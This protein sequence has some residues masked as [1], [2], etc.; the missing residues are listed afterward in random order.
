MV[1]K[2]LKRLNPYTIIFVLSI[3]I[4]FMSVLLYL[5]MNDTKFKQKK[6]MQPVEEKEQKQSVNITNIMKGGDDTYTRAPVPLRDSKLINIPT[7]GLPEQYQ[8]MGTLK[9]EEGTMLPLY[10]RRVASRSDRFNYYTRTD[11]YNPLPLPLEYNKKDC[12][13]DIGC[14]E[15]F[16]GDTVKITPTGQVASASLYKF[17]G[18]TYY[19]GILF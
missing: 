11:T 3:I 5:Y 4:V 14:N 2:G 12:Q 8:A 13:D 7:Q 9:T 1:A 19:P 18:P 17:G 16:S 10:G 15:I 6:P